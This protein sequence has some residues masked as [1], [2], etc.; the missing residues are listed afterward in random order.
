MIRIRP[1]SSS[2]HVAVSNNDHTTPKAPSPD[3]TVHSRP[4]TLAEI[5]SKRRLSLSALS[6]LTRSSSPAP[7]VN[8]V[9]SIRHRARPA[10]ALAFYPRP[11]PLSSLRAATQA[12]SNGLTNRRL[13]VPRSTSSRAI[14]PA[15]ISGTVRSESIPASASVAPLPSDSR[16]AA[17]AT[18]KKNRR[19]SLSALS[20]FANGNWDEGSW[21]RNAGIEFIPR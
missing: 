1:P 15:A 7:P 21:Q 11:P 5:K 8:V 12:D 3:L 10:S 19:F 16:L 9:T 6:N 13:E 18:K 4:K 20:N 2:S 14:S 17:D